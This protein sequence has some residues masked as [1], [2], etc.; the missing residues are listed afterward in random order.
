MEMMAQRVLITRKLSVV[1]TNL[2]F[3]PYN[4]APCSSSIA[5]G[6]TTMQIFLPEILT[7]EFLL[8]ALSVWCRQTHFTPLTNLVQMSS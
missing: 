4:P 8:M 7:K 1:F 2:S 3:S 6:G 5:P